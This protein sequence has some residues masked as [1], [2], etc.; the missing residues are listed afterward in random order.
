MWEIVTVD[1]FNQW[2]LSLDEAEQESILV[3]LFKLKEIG[4]M[5]GCLM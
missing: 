2:F 1:R 3:G 5:L 4:P